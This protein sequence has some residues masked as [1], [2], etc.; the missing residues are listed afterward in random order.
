MLLSGNSLIS[1]RLIPSG[2]FSNQTLFSNNIS[3]LLWLIFYPTYDQTTMKKCSLAKFSQ[4]IETQTEQK[5][6]EKRINNPIYQYYWFNRT[7]EEKKK[8][9]KS[10]EIS[11]VKTLQ[12]LVID[13]VKL[14]RVAIITLMNQETMNIVHKTRET[15]IEF[16]FY[17]YLLIIVDN[18]KLEMDCESIANRRPFHWHLHKIEDLVKLFT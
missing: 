11:C 7:R 17:I 12:L 5:K 10:F 2:Y 6:K 16:F 13:E 14:Y 8:Y 15:L 1:Y 4:F 9:I 3:L 18:N